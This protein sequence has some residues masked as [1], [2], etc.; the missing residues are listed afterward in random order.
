MA[1]AAHRHHRPVLAREVHGLHH[2]GLV[3]ASDDQARPPIDHRVP[4][5]ARRIVAG[6]CA[7][8]HLTPPVSAKCGENSIADGDGLT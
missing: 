7:G 8:Q 4:D 5:R 3:V 1:T 2:V 6:I